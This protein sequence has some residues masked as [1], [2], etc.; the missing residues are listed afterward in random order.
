MKKEFHFYDLPKEK[1]YLR[2][3][4]SFRR[5]LF[6]EAQK[7]YTS[8]NKL[9][10]VL[11]CCPHSLSNWNSGKYSIP[12]RIIFHLS[13]LLNKSFSL[14]EIEK[15]ITS[16]STG[17][18]TKKQGSVG[19]AISNLKF[20]IKISFKLSR[21]VANFI[22]DGSINLNYYFN[23]T[24]F[25]KEYKLI[26]SLKENI[27]TVFGKMDFN[28]NQSKDEV[29]YINV[30]AIVGLILVTWFGNFY[31]KVARVPFEILKG[32]TNWKKGFL[33]GIYDDEGT[34]DIKR[35]HLLIVSSSPYLIEDISK[36]LAW[37][38]IRPRKIYA[39][40]YTTNVNRLNRVAYHLVIAN[41]M[42]INRFAKNIGFLH[43]TKLEK[44]HKMTSESFKKDW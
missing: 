4:N 7:R 3:K 31:S 17:R 23:T 27:T 14:K 40:N 16:I 42:S 1:I 11:D 25:N 2:L 34:L 22:G 5:K 8:F 44:L 28:I 30:P 10:K 9:S 37:F 20:P 24:Y 43:P 19:K 26:E 18:M 33:Q 39:I 32:E 6:K 12:G 38:E 13:Y 35:G 36:L 15:N 29:Y 21:I 41:R